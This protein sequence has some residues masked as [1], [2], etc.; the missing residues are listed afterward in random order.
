ML[1]AL[2]CVLL[3]VKADERLGLSALIVLLDFSAV[4]NILLD[5]LILWKRLEVTFGV[6]DAQCCSLVVCILPE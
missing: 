5:H 3:L 1:S 6:R 2:D 4:F